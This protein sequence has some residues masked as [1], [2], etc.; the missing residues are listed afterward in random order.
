MATRSL[1]PPNAANLELIRILALETQSLFLRLRVE[2]RLRSIQG[3]MAE[4]IVFQ[5]ADGVIIDCN[6]SAEKTLGL[7]RDQ[8]LG[9]KSG[10][11]HWQAVHEDGRVFPGEEHPAMVSL[12]TGQPCRDVIMGLR[13]PDGGQ[14]WININTE[15]MLRRGE[16]RPYAVL[17]S[18]SDITKR[19]ET[20]QA[21]NI[22]LTEKTVLLK[23]V[24]HRVKNN[25]QLIISLLNLQAGQSQ[26]G[27]MSDFL[28][29]TRNRVRSMAIV[30]E[31]LCR[32]ENLAH[33]NLT[34]YLKH[35]CASLLR[36]AG[37]VRA[38][39]QI[40]SQVENKSISIGQTQAVPFGLLI[41]ELV[42]NA[43]KYAF[44][45]QRPGLIRVTIQS[46]ASEKVLLTVADDGVGLPAGLDPR[47]A[48]GLG[49]RLVCLLAKQLDGTVNFDRGQG[50]AVQILF[51][52][53]VEEETTHD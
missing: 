36:S 25:L 51:N 15:P 38:N 27:D 35:L 45:E 39:V 33:L 16:I 47:H 44:P 40:E 43:L 30:H 41:N 21:M 7:S 32:P 49:L 37:P 8:I 14:R 9:R 17:T 48:E 11:P 20:E 34:N 1:E 46:P 18:F 42:T 23:E 5:K 6:P 26:K 24:H 31:N 29:S 4:G 3:A 28:T 2:D 19:R 22:L 53:P 12:R 50:T 13:L 10:N 52:T